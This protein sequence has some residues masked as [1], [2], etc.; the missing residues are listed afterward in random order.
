MIDIS[1]NGGTIP[2]TTTEVL[3]VT[4]NSPASIY[5]ECLIYRLAPSTV[6]KI[7]VITMIIDMLRTRGRP[8]IT[9]SKNLAAASPSP[10]KAIPVRSQARNVLSFARWGLA[11]LSRAVRCLYS[12]LFDAS[13][14]FCVTFYTCLKAYFL[15]S[16]SF[17]HFHLTSCQLFLQI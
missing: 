16:E 9:A 15:A 14:S 4:L 6:I 2:A 7:P 3:I 17:S 11:Q 1:P 8:R 12:S 13:C 10:I 5:F